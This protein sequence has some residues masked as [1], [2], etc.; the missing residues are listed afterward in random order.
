M[1]WGHACCEAKDI[2]LQNMS[3][4]ITYDKTDVVPGD[5][6]NI[7]VDFNTSVEYA[8]IAIDNSSGSRILNNV[9]M[10]GLAADNSL[11]TTT[12]PSRT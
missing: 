7:T 1:E 6:V 5:I 8:N 12:I 9:S 10:E 3:A 2:A 11:L 4:N